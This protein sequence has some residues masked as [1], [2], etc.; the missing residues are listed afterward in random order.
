MNFQDH[1]QQLDR[2]DSLIYRK[3]T[4]T[5]HDLAQKFN[6][7][8]RSVYRLIED[9]RAF[10]FTIL[11]DAERRSYYYPDEREGLFRLTLGPDKKKT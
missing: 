5:P 6:I 2:L 1:L 4:G 7:S 8:E 9:L 11:Y 10:G 3:S